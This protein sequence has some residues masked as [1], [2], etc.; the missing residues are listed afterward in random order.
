MPV[1]CSLCGWGQKPKNHLWHFFS[2]PS[3]S[4][5]R[6][7]CFF[8]FHNCGPN[9]ATSPYFRISCPK[10]CTSLF[11][12]FI[13]ALG[14]FSS[15][16]LEESLHRR[17]SP[18][19]NLQWLAFSLENKIWS[20]YRGLQSSYLTA[21][22]SS[23][24]F[25]TPLSFSD[26]VLAA[27]A[28]LLFFSAQERKL[29]SA[30]FWIGLYVFLTLNCMSHLYIFEINPLS[31]ASFANIFSHSKG[32]IFVLFMVSFAVQKLLSLISSHLFIF[33]FIFVS[34]FF[35]WFTRSNTLLPHFILVSAQISPHERGLPLMTKSKRLFLP[36][37][38]PYPILF[39]IILIT[40]FIIIISY[41]SIYLSVSPL[42]FV[43]S[44]DFAKSSVF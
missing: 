4:L 28:H 35:S 37:F 17:F 23:A 36:H 44:R 32:W 11:T 33:V 14:L 16:Q 41:L 34:L 6:K 20:P 13:L 27:L 1:V 18:A 9:P 5:T 2:Y 21:A 42:L 10:L 7:C 3:W 30:H 38:L 22:T 40:I 39:F 19:V 25:P 29:S 24:L 43:E 15:Q 31:V 8:L 26:S 12:T